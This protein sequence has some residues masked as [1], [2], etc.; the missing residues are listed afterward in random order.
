MEIPMKLQLAVDTTV[1]DD[2]LKLVDDLQ[3]LVE[4]VEVGTPLIL[5]EGSKAIREI[6]QRHGG[7]AVLAD[8]KIMDAGACEAEIAFE[9]GADIVSVLGAANDITIQDAI[10]KAHQG[11]RQIMADLIAVE[12]VTGRANLLN[13]MH[14]DYVCVHTASDIPHQNP[15]DDLAAVRGVLTDVGIAVAG[16]VDPEIAKKCA[17]YHPDIVVV[18]S[19]ITG[20]TDP[21]R[22]ARDIRSSFR[23]EQ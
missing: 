11:D 7:Q 16:G 4:I 3:G 6:K 17:A 19:Y 2:A 13:E 9:A 15:T 20:S 12:D 10:E 18:G 21:C 1:L 8:F 22:A 23:F 5:K 14:V